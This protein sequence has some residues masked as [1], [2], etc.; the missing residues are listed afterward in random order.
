MMQN[1]FPHVGTTIRYGGQDYLIV[2]RTVAFD[3]GQI[4]IEVLLHRNRTPLWVWEL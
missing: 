3:L 4:S 1:F 2:A